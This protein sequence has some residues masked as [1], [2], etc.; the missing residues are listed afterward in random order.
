MTTLRTAFVLFLVTIAL[1]SHQALAASAVERTVA[2]A[3]TV[4]RGAGAALNRASDGGMP[5]TV[6]DFLAT[7]GRDAVTLISLRLKSQAAAGDFVVARFGQ[8]VEG[9][10][11]YG[12][13]VKAT[14][15]GDGNLVT[16]TDNLAMVSGFVAPAGIGHHDALD[17]ALADVRP[18]LATGL[19]EMGRSGKTVTFG[20]DSFF[21]SDPKVTSIAIAGPGGA[22]GE[23]FLVEIWGNEDNQLD[24]VVVDGAGRVVYVQNRTANESYLIFE[25]HPDAGVQTAGDSPDAIASPS[26]WLNPADSDQ[27][28]THI[29]GNNA[30]TYL[31]TNA[32]NVADG[33]VTPNDGVVGYGTFDAVHE[34]VAE[35]TVA[36]NQAVAIQNLFYLNNR[37]HDVL[38]GHGFIPGTGNFQDSDPVLAEA[39]DGSGTNNA[40]FSTPSD[41]TS[42]RMQMYLWDGIGDSL[43]EITGGPYIANIAAFGGDLNPS[44]TNQAVVIALDGNGSGSTTDACDAISNAGNLAGNIAL[45]DRGNCDFVVKVKNVQDAGVVAAIVV[46]NQGDG[47]ITMGGTDSAITIP[48]VFVGQSDGSAI[49]A[50]LPGNATLSANPSAPLMRDSALDGD[51]VWHE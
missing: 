26:G 40:N 17:A 14:F 5:A 22:L 8:E 36:A 23:G 35:P 46:N 41:G 3:G 1:A 9:L 48:A 21:F 13:G 47:I 20:G 29:K 28:P 43:I 31:D 39:Q 44:I 2:P 11:V 33:P 34:L 30:N 15:D 37:I 45:I 10:T 38:Y 16:L 25:E 49:V 42:P 4:Y 27:Y 50:V 12:A 51:I 7:Q 24:H 19:S 18:D 6:A 32:N